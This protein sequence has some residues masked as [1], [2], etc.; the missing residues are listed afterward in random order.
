[1]TTPVFDTL[2]GDMVMHEHPVSGAAEPI[3]DTRA[4]ILAMSPASAVFAQSTDH[5]D[6]FFWNESAWLQVPFPFVTANANPDMGAYQDSSR[7]GL[8]AN[9]VDDKL[10]TR[11]TIGTTYNNTRD[12][13]LRYDPSAASGAGFFGRIGG[14]FAKFVTGIVLRE[15]SSRLQFQP[16]GSSEWYDVA[17]MNSTS[18]G[19]NGLPITQDGQTSMGAYPAPLR[20][21]GGNKNMGMPSS[22]TLL[23]HGTIFHIQL[24]CMTDAEKD[25]LTAGETLQGEM[26]FVTDTLKVYVSNGAGTLTALN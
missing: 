26:I 3:T 23:L 11:V 14:A 2:L 19:L 12:G 17:R 13:E 20:I 25:A 7:I 6:L 15:L 4:N 1:M 10:L 5:N 9:Y 22:A 8:H 21:N 18:V 24:R 16:N